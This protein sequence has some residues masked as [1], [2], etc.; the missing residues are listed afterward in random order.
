MLPTSQQDQ[1]VELLDAIGACLRFTE[2]A[3]RDLAS[4]RSALL[5]ELLSGDHEIPI[6]YDKL[7]SA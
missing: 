6:T 1:L 4:T 2:G 5:A 3:A 7:L